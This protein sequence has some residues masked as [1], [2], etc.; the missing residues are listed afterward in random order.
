LAGVADAGVADAGAADAEVAALALGAAAV[1]V[2]EAAAGPTTSAVAGVGAE[3]AV[4]CSDCRMLANIGDEAVIGIWPMV[5]PLVLPRGPDVLDVA[6]E[7]VLLVVM[8][9]PFRWKRD[10][11]AERT[12]EAAEEMALKLMGDPS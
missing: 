12:V 4:C 2:L 1:A 7:V 5:M 11:A 6:V 8:W 10:H 9:A 3:A